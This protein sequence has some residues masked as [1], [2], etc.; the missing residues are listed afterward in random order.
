MTES[1]MAAPVTEVALPWAADG[2]SGT[3][4]EE[5]RAGLTA[6]GPARPRRIPS[7]F[8]YDE[9][10][11]HLF[12]EITRL[13]DY[14]PPRAE[15]RLLTEHGDDLVG[16]MRPVELVDLGAGSARKTE[17]LLAA[18][19]RH[20][21]LRAYTGVDVSPEPMREAAG[22]IRRRWPHAR[23]TAVRGDF[24]AALAWLR[25]AERIADTIPATAD[26]APAAADGAPAAAEGN[27]SGGR[28]LALLGN[29]LGN[30]SEPE[31]TRFLRAVRA[32]CAP[33]DHLLVCVD[34]SEPVDVVRRAYEAGYAG[35]RPVR[36]MFALNTLRH[37]NRR[38]G[39]D[40]DVDAFEPELTY[41]VA[42]REVRGAIR[43]VRRQRVTLP[44]LGLAVDF[45]AGELL[46]H[47]V[48]RKFTVDGLVRA[49]G[50]HGM[51]CRRHWVDEEFGYGAFLFAPAG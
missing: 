31:Q 36:R 9:A 51:R 10:G 26:S 41:D 15:R 30:L 48:V 7:L 1:R 27:G 42:R 20:G 21:L 44:R 23:V 24:L 14:Y 3:P 5:L 40:F 45:G 47:D 12:E 33:N 38:Y 49:V 2:L 50:A 29:T 13:P 16:L 19:D 22:R 32:G 4:E 25:R 35:P 39:A 18:M 8:G 46:L 43:S 28:L 17:I 11:S 37:L 34:L 6:P